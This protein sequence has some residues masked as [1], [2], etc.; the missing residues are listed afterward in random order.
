LRSSVFLYFP[1]L[2]IHPHEILYV[3]KELMAAALLAT[4]MIRELQR[5]LLNP[6]VSQLRQ[7]APP[8][9]SLAEFCLPPG[10]MRALLHW[11]AFFF[12]GHGQNCSGLFSSRWRLLFASGSPRFV[13]SITLQDRWLL[14][15]SFSAGAR[16]L[17]SHLTEFFSWA[18]HFP[19]RCLSLVMSPF[20]STT[21]SDYGDY[22]LS[23]ARH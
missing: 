5:R 2:S 8:T 7:M 20:H 18:E 17:K 23:R 16:G 9:R 14:H 4:Q 6:Y 19:P 10:V 3:I 13:S 12:S 11:S 21:L 22:V 15:I 1:S